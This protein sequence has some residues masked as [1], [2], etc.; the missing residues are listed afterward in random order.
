MEEIKHT[1][2]IQ[3]V[4]PLSYEEYRAY[5]KRDD[6]IMSGYFNFYYF[7]TQKDKRYR[8]HRYMG[9]RKKNDGIEKRLNTHHEHLKRF[10]DCKEV[11]IWIGSL[12]NPNLQK[13]KN[14]DLIETLFIR[15]YRNM[16]TVN[17]RK[18]Q[19]KISSSVCVINMWFNQND[20]MQTYRV[21]RPCF[22]DVILYYHEKNLFK[23]GNLSRIRYDDE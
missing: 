23:H 6:T 4:G 8:R 10:M 15:A 1:Y 20:E 12:A 11:W 7:E 14:I 17:T 18:K 13:D 19:M 3:W 21:E 9:I 2:T 22:D 16:L 5:I